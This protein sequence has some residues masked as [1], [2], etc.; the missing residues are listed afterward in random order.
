MDFDSAKQTFDERTAEYV[1]QCVYEGDRERYI[2]FMNTGAMLAAYYRGHRSDKI[3]YRE[4]LADGSVRWLKLSVDLVEYPNSREIEVYLMYEDIDKQKKDDLVTLERAETDPLTGI[5]NRATFIS[6]MELLLNGSGIGEKHA[7]LMLDVDN[8]KHVNDTLGHGAGDQVL[9][10]L[11]GSI[12]AMLRRDDLIGR[13]GGDEFFVFLKD[14]PNAEAV[15]AKA[16][17][18]CALTI[19]AEGSDVPVTASIGI[20]MV[21]QDGNDFDSLYKKADA[22]LYRQKNRGK[23]GYLFCG[24]GQGG[25]G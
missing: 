13:M 2:A 16:N 22:A 18:I 9:C 1:N 23:K 14:V 3:E 19:Y 21:P 7:L 20:A 11:T 8:F 6:R 5:L 24:D 10:D 17:K 12:S 4:Q 25:V 15:A